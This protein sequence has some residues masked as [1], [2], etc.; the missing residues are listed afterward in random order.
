MKLR[1]LA[2][3]GCAALA[4]SGAALAD[5]PEVLSPGQMMARL[6]HNLVLSGTLRSDAPP[7]S[8]PS[9]A[10]TKS[11]MDAQRAKDLR[12]G[13]D[14][15]K[16]GGTFA[17]LGIE[18]GIK[19]ADFL[20][21]YKPL[22]PDDASL[23]AGTNPAGMPKVPSKCV[24]GSGCGGCYE[25]AYGD[26]NNLR[27]AF[28]KLRAIGRWTENFTKKS[29]AFGDAA[30]GIHG[31]AGLAWQGERAKIE[32]SYAQ[33][34]TAYDAKYQELVGDLEGALHEI[35][36]CEA[37]FFG[38]DDWYDRYGFLYYSFMADRYRR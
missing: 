38:T 2:L 37:K 11:A 34:G 33:F 6:A 28:E 26:L 29:I 5:T 3:A 18:A 27:F 24:E 12:A 30:S 1:L 32:Q 4:A 14:V 36:Q 13:Y 31:V 17:K 21:A 20:K 25:K 9:S 8:P 16:D 10:P 19:A 7:A 15:V 23:G 22:S 35:G